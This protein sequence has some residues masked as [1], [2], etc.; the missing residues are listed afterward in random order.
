MDCSILTINQKNDDVIIT[1]HDFCVKFFDVVMFRLSNLVVG[2]S[3]KSTSLLV[4]E[5][6]EI[7]PE[8]WKSEIPSF[9]FCPISENWGKLGIPNSA[10]MSLMKGYLML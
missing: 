4:V 10:W 3:S 8:I 9:E 1:E 7:W 6:Q 5:L 2:P